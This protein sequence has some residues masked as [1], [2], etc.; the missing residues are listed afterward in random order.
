MKVLKTLLFVALF[1]FGGL[2]LAA[3]PVDINTA[4]AE[5]LAEGLVGI[6]KAKAQAIIADREQNGPFKSA[7]DLTRVKGIGAKTVEKNRANIN[8]GGGAAAPAPV[9]AK[10]AAPVAPP[11]VAPAPTPMSAAPK[12]V[13]KPAAIPAAP[14]VAP[15]ATPAPA[16]PAK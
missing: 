15:P 11:A 8:V 6:G 3:G 10:P 16:A 4:T 5:Q 13:P 7:D 12:A 14:P 1:W 9:A 2:A